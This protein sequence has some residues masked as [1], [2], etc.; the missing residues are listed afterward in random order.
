MT[1]PTHKPSASIEATLTTFL[2][3]YPVAVCN[4][5]VSL[6]SATLSPDCTR[7]LRP[8]EELSTESDDTEVVASIAN[9]T[10]PYRA[11]C[12]SLT[13]PQVVHHGTSAPPSLNVSP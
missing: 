12:L 6:L 7:H 8:E 1:S 3:N 13:L 9:I 4:K 10:I 2:E 11:P 5:D